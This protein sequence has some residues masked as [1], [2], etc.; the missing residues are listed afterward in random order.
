MVGLLNESPLFLPSTAFEVR[1]VL[2]ATQDTGR[3]CAVHCCV[4]IV[5]SASP[6]SCFPRILP[7]FQ[8]AG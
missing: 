2:Y 7:F 8:G 4:T 3:K 6:G 1:F 5:D